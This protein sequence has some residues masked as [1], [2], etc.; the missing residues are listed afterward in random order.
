M[1]GG[2][3]ETVPDSDGE[4]R[5]LRV[6]VRCWPVLFRDTASPDREREREGGR[7]QECIYTISTKK[8]MSIPLCYQ[9]VFAPEM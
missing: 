3:R 7:E 8:N 4:L 1:R 9:D 2:L 6:L 5:W